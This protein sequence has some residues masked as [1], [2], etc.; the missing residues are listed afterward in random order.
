MNILL[1][2]NSFKECADSVKIAKI[3]AQN[4][5]DEKSYNLIIKPLTDG[6]DGFL[7]VCKSLIK[8]ETITYLIYDNYRKQLNKYK[9]IYDKK[10]EAIFIESA[11]LFGMKTLSKE[12]LNPLVLNSEILG[13]LLLRIKDESDAGNITVKAVNIGVGGTA[14]IDFGIGACSQLGLTL[15][16]EKANVIKPIPENFIKVRSFEFYKIELPFAINFVVDVE[17]PLLGNPGAIEIY[18]EQKGATSKD[19]RLIKSGIIN[20][21][22]LFSKSSQKKISTNFNGAGG[23]LASGISV[24]Y[25]AEIINAKE[26]IQKNILNDIEPQKIDAVITGEGK[27]DYQSFE[28]KGIGVL[29]NKFRNEEI[30]IFIICGI[31]ELQNQI[32]LSKNIKLIELQKFFSDKDDSIKNFQL[33]LSKASALIKSELRH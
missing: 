27:F 29:L 23:G 6:G 2:P 14:T 11:E 3:L 33:G 7:S 26:F 4:L 18:G 5:N 16:D 32:T 30:P 20:L 22:E 17:T 24:F 9:V 31:A 25:D 1:A 15:L 8:G 12:E 28:G 13:N 21:I 19:L 10:R